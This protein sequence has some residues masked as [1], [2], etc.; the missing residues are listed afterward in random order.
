MAQ[1]K[2]NT[3]VVNRHCFS[4]ISVYF[5]ISSLINHWYYRQALAGPLPVY[6]TPT[7]T[8]AL[9]SIFIE[10]GLSCNVNGGSHPDAA[11]PSG[12]RPKNKLTANYS[13]VAKP[14]S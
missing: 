4:K 13:D 1:R 7:Q 14:K 9:V 8:D 11:R 2:E 10:P 12:L 5:H 3:I 6:D